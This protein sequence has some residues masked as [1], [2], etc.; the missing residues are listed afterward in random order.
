MGRAV[1]IIDEFTVVL[2][3]RY[4]ARVLKVVP[5]EE[6]SLILLIRDFTQAGEGRGREQFN[7]LE[8]VWRLYRYD[9]P[10]AVAVEIC[11]FTQ[12]ADSP[13]H[14]VFM[15][16]AGGDV[17]LLFHT[18]LLRV[19]VA[20]RRVE[21]ICRLSLPSGPDGEAEVRGLAMAPDTAVITVEGEDDE[22]SLHWIPL[23]DRASHG[24]RYPG[25]RGERLACGAD[26]HV[27]AL[28]LMEIV[29]YQDG[30]M[31]GHWDLTPL[32]EDWFK[33][34]IELLCTDSQGQVIAGTGDR[35]L[36]LSKDLSTIVAVHDLPSRPSDVIWSDTRE[37]LLL[38]SVDDVAGTLLVQTVTL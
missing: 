9:P 4:R 3:Q 5:F 8:P 38:T 32:F 23:D 29:H 18:Q 12:P 36:R 17:F 22:I 28:D 10:S 14:P 19:D 30:A 16:A 1:E 37:Q 7:D 35:V 21:S 6:R 13:L 27:Y 25:S 24:R 34:P 31:V 11:I 15:A 20:G 2:P 26:G 33:S